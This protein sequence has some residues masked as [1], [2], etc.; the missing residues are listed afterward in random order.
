MLVGGITNGQDMVAA[1]IRERFNG[2]LADLVC[3]M[4]DVGE[5]GQDYET[6]TVKETS[7]WIWLILRSLWRGNGSNETKD[8]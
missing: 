8:Q 4:A 7:W 5:R 2:E 1:Y 3:R 6:G